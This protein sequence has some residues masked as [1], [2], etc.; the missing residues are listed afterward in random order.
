MLVLSMVVGSAVVNGAY[1]LPNYIQQEPLNRKLA[2]CHNAHEAADS[3]CNFLKFFLLF[4]ICIHNFCSTCGCPGPLLGSFPLFFY[5]LTFTPGVGT[6]QQYPQFPRQSTTR[7][8]YHLCHPIHFYLPF[9]KLVTL[10]K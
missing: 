9:V 1:F 3:D 10:K 6:H 4:S 2:P 7:R 8:L 5:T